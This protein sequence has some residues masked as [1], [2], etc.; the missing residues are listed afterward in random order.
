MKQGD[1][2]EV[3]EDGS[4]KKLSEDQIKEKGLEK[5]VHHHYHTAPCFLQHYPSTWQ[6]GRPFWQVT[7][8]YSWTTTADTFLLTATESSAIHGE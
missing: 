7:T 3:Q 1:L 6:T 4:L 8:P 2:Y 5:E